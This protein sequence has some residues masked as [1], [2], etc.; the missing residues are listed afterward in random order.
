MGTGLGIGEH[1]SVGGERGTLLQRGVTLRP[2][3]EPGGSAGSG[4]EQVRWF[5]PAHRP[6]AGIEARYRD[7]HPLAV[8]R[9]GLRRRLSG[10]T[11]GAAEGT[12]QGRE[13]RDRDDDRENRCT[14]PAVPRFPV[15][16]S[17]EPFEAVGLEVDRPTLT[18]EQ[19]CDARHRRPPSL[20]G[21]N[22]DL[23]ARGTGW[24]RPAP[25][26]HARRLRR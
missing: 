3:Q 13:T 14:H 6:R 21:T 23:G 9:L 20:C 16:A 17:D 22:P 12:N 15:A 19:L 25:R 5:A 10:W 24:S 18:L 8:P 26:A 1:G 11:L 2:R 7:D 4:D